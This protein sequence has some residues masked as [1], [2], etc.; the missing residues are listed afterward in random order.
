MGSLEYVPMFWGPKSWAKWTLRKVEMVLIP[1]KHLLAFNE[2]DVPS[3][4]NMDPDDA[5]TLYMQEI[6][7][8]SYRGTSLGSPAIAWNLDWMAQF[9]DGI[10]KEGGHVD[11]I[12]LHW[13]VSFQIPELLVIHSTHTHEFI[14]TVLGAICLSSSNTFNPPTRDSESRFG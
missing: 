12:V 4:A 14:G 10:Q 3:Q 8:W 6:M 7:P 5:V 11:F 9:L 13:F 1:P 2:P